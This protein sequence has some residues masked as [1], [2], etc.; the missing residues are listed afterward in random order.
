MKEP[1]KVQKFSG[2]L[3][4]FDES[5][6]IRSLK[7]ARA[8]D[9]LANTI[10]RQIEKDLFDGMTTKAIYDKAF[11]LLKKKRRP[12]AARYKLKRAIMEL[13]PSGFPFEHYIGHI[14]KHDGY[15]TDVGIVM[16][17]NCIS[18]E[19]DV[20]ACKEEKCYIIECKYHNSQGKRNDVK[21]PLYIHS[22]F[23]DLK[24]RMEQDKTNG[25]TKFQGWI[26][27]NTRFTSDAIKYAKC[28]GLQLVSWDYPKNKSLKY[29]INKSRLFPITSLTSLTKREKQY[30]LE[31]GIVLCKEIY[32]APELLRKNGFSKTRIRKIHEDI[33]D[34]CENHV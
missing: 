10:V 34:L 17:G 11:R 8:D 15:S 3:V 20:L 14:F 1:I 28:S 29:R 27:T 22:R 30:F 26:F 31:Q 7:N 21:V 23:N 2:D 24:S 6:L 32:E 19:V 16:E 12:S 4:D 18:H 33:I 5:K 9:E 13:G 25:F